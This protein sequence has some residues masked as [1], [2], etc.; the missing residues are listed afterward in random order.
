MKHHLSSRLQMDSGSHI[1][2]QSLHNPHCMS[3]VWVQ[4]QLEYKFRMKEMHTNT[5]H[6]IVHC[7][8]FSSTYKTV[9][10]KVIYF[11]F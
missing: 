2:L 3:G 8:L 6:I 9:S 4:A 10:E 1:W 7:Q 5:R 11:F